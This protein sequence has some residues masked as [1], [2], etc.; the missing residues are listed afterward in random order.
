MQL[1]LSA[2]TALSAIHSWGLNIELLFHFTF[3]KGGVLSCVFSLL[4]WHKHLNNNNKKQPITLS[5]LCK[6]GQTLGGWKSPCLS[7]LVLHVVSGTIVS[8]HPSK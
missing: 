7:F 5:S 3:P 4:N 8:H 1:F 6:P 2:C